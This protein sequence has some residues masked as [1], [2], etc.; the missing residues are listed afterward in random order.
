M[1]SHLSSATDSVSFAILM[2]INRSSMVVSRVPG[3]SIENCRER[4]LLSIYRYILGRLSGSIDLPTISISS[5]A[6]ARRTNRA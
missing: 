4:L 1:K 3:F 2:F 5:P 6:S